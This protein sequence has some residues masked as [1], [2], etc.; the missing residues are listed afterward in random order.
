MVIQIRKAASADQDAIRDVVLSAFSEDESQPIA[1]LAENLLKEQTRPETLTL[2]AETDGRLVGHIAFSPVGADKNASWLGYILAPLAVKPD[3]HKQGIGSK[4]IK[5]GLERLTANGVDS[6]FVYGDPAYYGRFGFN[7]EAA[8]KYQP[9]YALHY[10][11]GWQATVLRE[12]GS[13]EQIIR[14]SCVAALRD[15][16]LW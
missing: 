7:A 3:Y 15:P 16:S 8:E 2:V 4:L 5:S 13:V 6:V 12:G 9:P 1:T 14:F 11:F 10:P